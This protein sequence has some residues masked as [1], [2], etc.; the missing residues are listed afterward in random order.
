MLKN[1]LPLYRGYLGLLAFVIIGS[2]LASLLDLFLPMG[3]RY[4]L[5]DL[6]PLGDIPAILRVAAVLFALYIVSFILS[7][8]VFARGRAMGASIEYD[9][10]VRLFRHVLDMGFKYFDNA[11]TGQL[12]SRL[13]GDIAEIGQLMFS[14]P[15]LLIVC[16]I[17]MLGTICMLFYI[18]V[19]LAAVVSLLLCF[20]AYEAVIIN[21][22]MKESFV[23]ARAETAT[24]TSRTSESLSAIRLV[25]AFNNE[26][27]EEE[28]LRRA[29]EGLLAIQRET[30]RIVGRMNSSLSFFSNT[31]NLVIIV[32][33]GVLTASGTVALSDLITFLL[34]M[35][36]FMKPVFQLT[37]LTEVYQR[38]MAGFTRY[39]ELMAEPIATDALDASEQAT[40]RGRIEFEHVTFGYDSSRPVLKDFSLTIEPGQMVAVVGPT[41]SGKSTLCQ[42]L[43]RLYEHDSGRILIDGVDIYKYPLR[44]LRSFIGMV[45]QDV[46]LFSDSIADNIAYGR[47]GASADEIAAAARN[48]QA[49]EFIEALPDKYATSVGERGVKLSGGQ[50][51]RIAI[52]RIFLKNPPILILDEATSALDN[53]T[54]KQVQSAMDSL[55]RERTTLVVAHRL[56]TIQ[57]ADK[58]I[59]LDGGEIRESGTHAELMERR[60]MYYELY[61]T[62]FRERG[63]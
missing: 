22:R 28:K 21:R 36:I 1:L 42:L 25:K 29:G 23:D 54:E 63:E 35:M 41:G 52:A 24:V 40:P 33:G 6:L 51:Q 13:V 55:A 4:I 48:A 18:S 17:T 60:G 12:I 62:Q 34:Y 19:P 26:A 11:F 53:E 50:K 15:H 14:I 61:M 8:Q 3:I 20:K 47:P 38:G 45:Q 46:F 5:N 39:Q 58:I 37:V 2:L 57:G 7:W 16:V 10:R 31:T 30:F 59:V 49:E 32:L 9:L 43:L 44:Q 56:A 27:L